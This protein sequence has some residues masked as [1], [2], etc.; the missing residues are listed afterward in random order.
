MSKSIKCTSCQQEIPVGKYYELWENKGGNKEGDYCSL[1]WKKMQ[2][3][4]ESLIK[5]G[6]FKVNEVEREREQKWQAETSQI[7]FGFRPILSTE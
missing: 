2:V 4:Y 1:C 7:L 3:K 6:D 5:Q